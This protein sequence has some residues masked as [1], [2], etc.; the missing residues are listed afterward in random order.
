VIRFRDDTPYQGEDLFYDPAAPDRFVVRCTRPGAAAMPGTCLFERRL[1]E[2]A[3][4]IVRFPRDW[5]AEWRPLSA[6]IEKLIARLQLRPAN[7]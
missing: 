2:S 4:V 6:G 3:D 5:L 1:G 7:S